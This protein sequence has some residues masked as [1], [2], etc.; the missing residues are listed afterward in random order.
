[1]PLYE[2]SDDKLV[3]FRL[4]IG[5]SQIYEEEIE[6]LLWDNLDLFTGESWFPVRRQAPISSGG[7]PD[8]V[9]LDKSGRVV[10]IEV[11]R[12]VERSQLAQA[13]EYAGW[14]R[15]TSL[16]E[17]AG[18][19][20]GGLDQFF[21]A[22]Q[23]FTE[24]EAP[25]VIN[26]N[27]ELVLVARD[28]HDRSSDAFEFLSIGKLPIRLIRV[29]IYED[30]QGRRFLD[31]E[32]EHEPDFGEETPTH[33]HTKI[34]GRRVTVADLLEAGLVVPGDTLTWQRPRV[35]DVHK[36]EINDQGAIVLEDGRSFTSPS[37]A[38]VKSA[39][40]PA[41]DGW[42]AWTVDRNGKLLDDLRQELATK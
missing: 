39:G 8:I 6:R 34:K 20:H 5:G 32:S 21:S 26:P 42:H 35:G 7:K 13:L 3:G 38:A 17:I 41:Y 33:D 16:D 29:S 9:A 23:I 22:W 14:A 12:D 37:G 28:F 4:L 19:Y 2:I 30:A 27:P 10:V 36:A 1:M 24:S 25:V 40:I 11:K 31:I 18:L 15:K